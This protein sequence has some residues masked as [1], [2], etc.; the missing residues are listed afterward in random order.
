MKVYRWDNSMKGDPIFHCETEL[1]FDEMDANGGTKPIEM[2]PWGG[3]MLIPITGKNTIKDIMRDNA[4]DDMR[5]QLVYSY[6]DKKGHIDIV[7]GERPG[8]GLERIYWLTLTDKENSQ[9]TQALIAGLISLAE[10]L[11]YERDGLIPDAGD[12]VEGVKNE[13]M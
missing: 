4:R 8:E 5:A 13:G 3:E 10:N 7:G 12:D 11:I 9:L 2:I 1:C 6:G